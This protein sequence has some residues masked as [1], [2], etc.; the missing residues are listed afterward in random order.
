MRSSCG[1]WGGGSGVG[2]FGL[3]LTPL[4]HG[5]GAAESSLPVQAVGIGWATPHPCPSRRRRS[6]PQ[7]PSP[8]S[9]SESVNHMCCSLPE[10][11]SSCAV[12][13]CLLTVA[14]EKGNIGNKRSFYFAFFHG[15][16]SLFPS[17]SS[18]FSRV[19]PHLRPFPIARPSSS[20]MFL[21]TICLPLLTF[22]PSLGTF[23]S[24]SSRPLPDILRRFLLLLLLF[25]LALS[26]IWAHFELVRFFLISIPAERARV[27][28]IS[29]KQR[30]FTHLG[31]PSEISN[32]VGWRRFGGTGSRSRAM[33]CRACVGG[34]QK[35]RSQA[36]VEVRIRWRR[37]GGSGS[38]LG[39]NVS[40]GGGPRT[41]SP[42]GQG[43]GAQK[44]P[45]GGSQDQRIQR[46][47]MLGPGGGAVG[48]RFRAKKCQVGTP[49]NK[50]SRGSGCPGQVA[51]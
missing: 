24:A 43:A 10:S 47:R 42:E 22:P 5:L 2:R 46:V 40:G 35:Q 41:G 45:R 6:S 49:K 32:G 3:G 11:S 9:A 39:Q 18:P 44:L 33:N 51:A 20:L 1:Q 23:S 34:A 27:K 36:G 19:F 7:A 38:V 8:H 29:V 31:Q 25:R 4:R 21:L 17:L 12:A 13:V 14:V 37:G 28:R 30:R 48:G 26:Q 15:P 16:L 50:E